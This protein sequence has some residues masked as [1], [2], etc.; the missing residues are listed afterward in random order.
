MP[1]VFEGKLAMRDLQANPI[2]KWPTN[3]PIVKCTGATFW[4]ADGVG[5]PV[6]RAVTLIPH[7]REDA[8]L[9]MK[10]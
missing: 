3:K 5:L 7:R 6:C 4:S 2:K 1:D 8:V 10:C 9:H